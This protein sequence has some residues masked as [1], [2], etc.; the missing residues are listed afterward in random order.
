MPYYRRAGEVPPKR[1]TQHRRPEGGLY[2]EL[3]GEEGFSSDSSLLYHVGLSYVVAGSPSPRYRN[4]VGDECVY[5]EQGSATVETVFGHLEVG[6]GDYVILPR[7]TTH[8]WVPRGEP[9]SSRSWS[10]PFGPSSSA[11]AA[12]RAT[13]ARTP[14]PGAVGARSRGRYDRSPPPRPPGSASPEHR[15]ERAQHVRRVSPL[16]HTS[17]QVV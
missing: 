2:E 7:A 9:T 11:R 13:T 12:G 8:R 4:D 15:G 1:H 16:R 17:G 3:V 6:A 10:T 5:L 14:G